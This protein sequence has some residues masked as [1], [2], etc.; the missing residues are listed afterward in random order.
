MN[1]EEQIQVIEDFLDNFSLGSEQGTKNIFRPSINTSLVIWALPKLIT[2]DTFDK[3]ELMNFRKITL[4]LVQLENQEQAKLFM[5]YDEKKKKW[6]LQI[7]NMITEQ[8][9]LIK[10][11][12]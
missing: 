10:E 9:N 7:M 5:H 1:E 2:E 12:A 8:N 4:S 11:V 6:L 3:L